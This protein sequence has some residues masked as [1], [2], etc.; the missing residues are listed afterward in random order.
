[1]KII[2]KEILISVVVHVICRL[3]Y[4]C[5]Q[6]FEYFCFFMSRIRNCANAIWLKLDLWQS[7]KEVNL[8]STH[9]VM[10]VLFSSLRRF[11][12]LIHTCRST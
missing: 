5:T 7:N 6:V 3:Y 8:R 11:G 10:C 2:F 12:L 1:M 9:Y 4:G